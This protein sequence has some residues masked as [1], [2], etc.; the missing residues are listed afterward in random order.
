MTLAGCTESLEEEISDLIVIPGCNDD[1][2]V[3]FDENAT[4]SDAC[5]TE[6]AL[7]QAIMDL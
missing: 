5:L 1:T 7:E 6:L 2:A 3:N 4:N